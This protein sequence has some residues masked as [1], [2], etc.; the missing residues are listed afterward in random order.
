MKNIYRL[1]LTSIKPIETG[2]GLWYSAWV[3]NVKESFTV[4]EILDFILTN[5]KIEIEEKMKMWQL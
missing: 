1:N 4:F 5:G 2:V 3:F